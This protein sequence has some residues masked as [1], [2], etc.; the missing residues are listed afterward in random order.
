M[1]AYFPGLVQNM[2][3]D[4]KH[5]CNSQ[6]LMYFLRKRKTYLC[7]KVK[8]QISQKCAENDIIQIYL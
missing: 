7:E 8:R 2:Q 4:I 3:Q 5:T 1:T 6:E